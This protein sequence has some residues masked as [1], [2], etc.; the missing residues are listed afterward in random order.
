[1]SRFNRFCAKAR[2]AAERVAD[3]AEEL[4]DS[5]A[6]SVKIKSLEMRID[7]KYEDLGRVIYRDLHTDEVLE[8][9]KLELIA[10]IDALYDE[11]ALLKGEDPADEEEPAEDATT[12]AEEDGNEE[13]PAGAE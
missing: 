1:M 8:E 9:E 6:R 12:A 11:L 7:E 13:T 3:K 5:A 2:R 10:A 4:V